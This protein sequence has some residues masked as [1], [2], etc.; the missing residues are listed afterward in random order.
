MATWIR[1]PFGAAG[2]TQIPPGPHLAVLQARFGGTVMLCIDVSGSMDGVPIREAVRGAEEFVREAVAARYKVGVMLWNTHV[3]ALAE[4]TADGEAAKRMLG[5]VDHAAGGNDLIGPLERCHEVLDQFTGDRVVALF[6]DGDLTPK[7]RVLAKVAQMKSQN[8]RFVTRGL[9]AT[10]AREFGEISSEEAAT[11]T[12]SR[13][14]DLA[15]GIAGMAAS[16]RPG[17]GDERAR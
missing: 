15:A 9:G 17:T 8:I 13:V 4:P 5:P 11:A 6:G 10:A 7:D 14:E 2:L 1:R 16:L 3:V 12:V